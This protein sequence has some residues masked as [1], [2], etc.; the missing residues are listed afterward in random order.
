MEDSNLPM[1]LKASKALLLTWIAS[2]HFRHLQ[3][4]KVFGGDQVFTR[5]WGFTCAAASWGIAAYHHTTVLLASKALVS[6]T[7]TDC[8]RRI[9]HENKT[10]RQ[11]FRNT[12]AS[13]SA[14]HISQ[15]WITTEEVAGFFG[16]GAAAIDLYEIF[17]RV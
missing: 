8:D 1:R 10:K 3:Q 13:M 9:A 15:L 12:I 4:I 2:D 11:I 17:P 5:N 7:A 14:M 16:A 6:E